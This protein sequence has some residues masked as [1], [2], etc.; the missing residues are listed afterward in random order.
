MLF[1]FD[2]EKSFSED[3]TLIRFSNSYIKALTSVLDVLFS[4]LNIEV[5]SS[6][7]VSQMNGG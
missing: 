4:V 6:A 2:W 7:I 1:G 5:L 3:F